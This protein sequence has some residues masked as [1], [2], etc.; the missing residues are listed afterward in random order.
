ML[1]HRKIHCRTRPPAVLVQRI[2][3]LRVVDENLFCSR[4]HERSLLPARVDRHSNRGPIFRLLDPAVQ[5]VPQAVRYRQPR[6]HLPRVHK[7]KVVSLAPHRGF[8]EL[9][10]ARHGGRQ[11][12]NCVRKR[13]GRQK[14]RQCIRQRITRLNVML[15][16]RG[17]NEH[18]RVR[19]TA[20]ERVGPVRIRP[21]NGRILIHADFHAP[22]QTVRTARV[23]HVLF[24][25]VQISKR[26]ENR[27]VRIVVWRV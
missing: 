4:R 23:A 20:S 6:I 14:S 12:R 13:S 15:P 26:T 1:A 17:R 2:N 3:R 8:V 27:S 19:G 18:R 22:F 7:I 21:E 16:A 9:R 11:C 25:L 5:L 24:H 10:S